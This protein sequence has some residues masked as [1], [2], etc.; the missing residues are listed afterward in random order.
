RWGDCALVGVIDGLGHGPFAQR[1]AVTARSFVESHYDRPLE[2]IF[3]GVGRACRATRGVVMALVQFS[4]T[5]QG[6]HGGEDESPSPPATSRQWSG[7]RFSFASIGNIE[8]RVLHPPEPINLMIR[9][10]VLGGVAP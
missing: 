7:V 6:A 3:R 10:G 9:R 8:A 2:E 5:M 1:A 4:V